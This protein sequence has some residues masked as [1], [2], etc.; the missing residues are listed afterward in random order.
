MFFKNLFVF[1]HNSTICDIKQGYNRVMIDGS[2]DDRWKTAV[3]KIEDMELLNDLE[4][5]TTDLYDPNF[6]FSDNE[7][8]SQVIGG[9][10]EMKKVNCI[11]SDFKFNCP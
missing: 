2:E 5:I 9:Y 11:Q 1:Y 10:V 7:D 3:K 4:N 8:A 6:C